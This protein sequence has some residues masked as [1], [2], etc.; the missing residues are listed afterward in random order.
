MRARALVG[1]EFLAWLASPAPSTDANV[2]VVAAHP[3][4][5]VI[6]MGG[7]VSRLPTLQILHVTDGAPRDGRDAA[8]QGF[9]CPRDYAAARR[10]ELSAALIAAGAGA[11]PTCN[12]GI[13]DQEAALH[14]TSVTRSVGCF[15]R[16][17]QPAV[18]MTHPYE[19]GHPDH[20]ATAFAVHAACRLLATEGRT[21][22][23]MIEMASYHA[24]E[25]GIATGRFL[26]AEG[27]EPLDIVLGAEACALKRRMYACFVTQQE[28]LEGFP[29]GAEAFRPAPRYRFLEAPHSGRLHYEKFPWGMT[30]ERFRALAAVALAVLGLEDGL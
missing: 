28:V 14:L 21:P 6:G 29:V 12:V 30:G 2:M 1:K 23:A 27:V 20:D 9:A 13:P 25:Q 24:G 4:D 17:R 5:E 7:Q 26:P 8:S 10:R 11:V 3:D 18:I 15:V 22:P 19:G 16:E